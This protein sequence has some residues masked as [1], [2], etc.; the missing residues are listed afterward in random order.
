MGVGRTPCLTSS[1]CCWFYLSVLSFFS[2]RPSVHSNHVQQHVAAS[3]CCFTPFLL[4]CLQLRT[5]GEIRLEPLSASLV[6][7]V[8]AVASQAAVATVTMTPGGS[9][10]VCNSDSFYPGQPS[11]VPAQQQGSGNTSSHQER[12]MRYFSMTQPGDTSPPEPELNTSPRVSERPERVG[13]PSAGHRLQR[14]VA[15]EGRREQPKEEEE[16]VWWRRQ[17]GASEDIVGGGSRKEREKE[18]EGWQQ[19]QQHHPQHPHPQLSPEPLSL[20][21]GESDPSRR[22]ADG[23]LHEGRERLEAGGGGRGRGGYLRETAAVNSS[24]TPERDRS[25]AVIPGRRLHSGN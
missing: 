5:A 7:S 23:D 21:R 2:S 11:A 20:W 10:A 1:E 18:Q 19:P 3:V 22:A 13:A 14:E 24:S 17:G 16:E 25:Q 8:A 6:R 4:L 12:A 15:E 9:A